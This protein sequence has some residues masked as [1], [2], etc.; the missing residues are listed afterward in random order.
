MV[1]AEDTLSAIVIKDIQLIQSA[2]FAVF[3]VG[4]VCISEV[5]EENASVRL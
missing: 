5:R 4:H 3:A 2:K 1:P